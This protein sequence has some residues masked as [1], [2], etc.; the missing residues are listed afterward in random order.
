VTP[1]KTFLVLLALLFTLGAGPARV[2]PATEA[3]LAQQAVVSA[4]EEMYPEVEVEIVWRPCGQ[5]NAF[6]YPSDK[7]I[8]MCTETEKIPGAAVFFAAHEMGH[9]VAIQLLS[10]RDEAA[11]DE[12]AALAMLELGMGKELLE[13][14]IY[15]KKDGNQ[16]H[17]DGDSHPSHGYRAWFLACMGASMDGAPAACV[18]LANT[19]RMKWWVRLH[20]F[21]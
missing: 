5:V 6:Y 19:T 9:A 21:R 10:T 3:F 15:F 14:A 7:R 20:L 8:V 13:A 18:N 11:A 1:L 16:Y 2:A 12:I 4:M 17:E